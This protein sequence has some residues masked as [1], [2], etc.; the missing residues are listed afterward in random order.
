[1]SGKCGLLLLTFPESNPAW[2]RA[3]AV[4]WTGAAEHP[5]DNRV[6]K[7]AFLHTTEQSDLADGHQT[8]SISQDGVWRF[9]AGVA[10][11]DNCYWMENVHYSRISVSWSSL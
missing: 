6:R 11:I 3:A 7:A 4:C 2:S 5:A 1:M 8:K 10:V 9:W